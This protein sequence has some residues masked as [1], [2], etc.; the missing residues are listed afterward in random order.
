MM[1][2]QRSAWS[3]AGRTTWFVRVYTATTVLAIFA[4][5]VAFLW[6][7]LE[8]RTYAGAAGTLVVLVFSVIQYRLATRIERE[9]ERQREAGPGP[10]SE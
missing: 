8:Q 3:R 1:A 2:K 7:S 10:S 4:I 9:R 6:G 5:V